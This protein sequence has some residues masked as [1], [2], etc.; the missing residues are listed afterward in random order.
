MMITAALGSFALVLT[1]MVLS[2]SSRRTASSAPREIEI[3]R[4]PVNG[5]SPEL[6]SAPLGNA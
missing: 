2:P 3:S 6:L 1:G 5:I 4:E